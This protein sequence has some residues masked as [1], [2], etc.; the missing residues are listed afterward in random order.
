MKHI[1]RK[2]IAVFS[3]CFLVLTQIVPIQAAEITP[4]SGG[5]VSTTTSVT[6]CTLSSTYWTYTDLVDAW[7]KC[8]NYTVSRVITKS[9]SSTINA[10]IVYQA[11]DELSLKMGIEY[12]TTVSTSA[13]IGRTFPADASRNSKLRY[14]VQMKKFNVTI[15][16]VSKYYDTSLGYYTRTNDYN[17]TVT[18]PNKA[19]AYIEVY[20]Q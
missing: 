2:T 14:R 19:Q 4:Y 16:V 1:I 12:G 5:V 17:G 8:S 6:K 9:S 15:R 20:Y 11:T 13:S 18:V 7:G 10:G 3:I